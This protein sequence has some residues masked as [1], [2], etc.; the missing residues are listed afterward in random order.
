MINV[1]NNKQEIRISKRLQD[2]IAQTKVWFSASRS[3]TISK[4]IDRKDVP[5]QGVEVHKR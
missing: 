5:V 3:W 4:V 2:L 1:V